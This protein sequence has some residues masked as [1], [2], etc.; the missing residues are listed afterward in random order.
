[1]SSFQ[2]LNFNPRVNGLI[3]DKAMSKETAE[4]RL[5]KTKV[6]ML[7]KDFSVSSILFLYFRE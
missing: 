7:S 3:K 4:K 5:G 6:P 2:V 1:M